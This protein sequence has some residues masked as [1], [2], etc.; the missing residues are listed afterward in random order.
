M[1]GT[2]GKL[3]ASLVTATSSGG[4]GAAGPAGPAGATGPA[5][6]A[7]ISG[8]QIVTKVVT[9]LGELGNVTATCPTGAKILGGAAVITDKQGH[10][11][12]PAGSQ[13]YVSYPPDDHEWSANYQF[14]TGTQTGYNVTAYAICA[15][16]ST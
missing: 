14:G 16:A 1:V 3:P 8:Y 6:P 2:N 7:G 10:P 4:T 13:L 15:N 9:S 5:G 11:G 12:G